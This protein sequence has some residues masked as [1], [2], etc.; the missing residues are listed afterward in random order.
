MNNLDLLNIVLCARQRAQIAA[1][2]GDTLRYWTE[3]AAL[4]T[5]LGQP[6]AAATFEQQA[7]R[8]TP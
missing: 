6:E 2:E 4:H 3:M 7:L 5:M 8:Y 1:A